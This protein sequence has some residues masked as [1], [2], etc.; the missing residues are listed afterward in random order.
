MS[1]WL[2]RSARGEIV[3]SAYTLFLDVCT[4]MYRKYKIIAYIGLKYGICSLCKSIYF[5][6]FSRNF[7]LRKICMELSKLPEEAKNERSK[8]ILGVQVPL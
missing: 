7:K 6:H 4:G 8:K 1:D 3:Y 5:T 2:P